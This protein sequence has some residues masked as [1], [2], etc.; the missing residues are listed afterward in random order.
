M[1]L[2]TERKLVHIVLVIV[3]LLDYFGLTGLR[4]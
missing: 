1:I 2:A 4:V 3:I